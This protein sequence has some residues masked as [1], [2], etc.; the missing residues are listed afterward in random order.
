[1]KRMEFG[2]GRISEP[3]VRDVAND[4]VTWRAG[5]VTAVK[6][7]LTNVSYEGQGLDQARQ[8]C[9]RAFARLDLD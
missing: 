1:M 7:K 2:G 6:S 3:T 8:R 5:I 4:L 9:R